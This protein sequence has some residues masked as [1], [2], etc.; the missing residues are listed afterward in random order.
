[1]KNIIRLN[2][3]NLHRLIEGCVNK[4]LKEGFETDYNAAMNK[5]LSRNG[6]WGMELKNPE[7]E[8]EYDDV[9]FSPNDMTMSCMGAT[10]Q[11]D[12]DM[13]VDQNLEALHEKLMELGYD[14]E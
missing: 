3:E 8:W 4:A 7:G 2:E 12:P 5:K 1:M 14:S 11:V 9:N 13:S 6:M 10:I